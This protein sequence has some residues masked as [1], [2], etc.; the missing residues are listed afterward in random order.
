[1]KATRWLRI[2][3]AAL[4]IGVALAACA[5]VLP[6]VKA[7]QTASSVGPVYPYSNSNYTISGYL[8]PPVDAGQNITLKLSGYKPNSLSLSF[9]P[10]RDNNVSPSGTPLL[11]VASLPWPV[12]SA[13]VVAP[14]TQ[15]YG[16]YITSTNRTGF[17]IT[18]TSVW[19]PFYPLRGYVPEGVFLIIFGVL[20]TGYFSAARRREREEDRVISEVA[21][22][23][24]EQR[25]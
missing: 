8:I 7:P 23:R 4:I 1:M 18:I 24:R 6:G 15:F 25:S 17:S 19:S 13:E 11:F 5:F 9:F 22:R 12:F 14:A 21:A 2:S 10:S 3:E 20:G 16:I